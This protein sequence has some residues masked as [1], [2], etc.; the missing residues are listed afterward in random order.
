MDGHH[1][2]ALLGFANSGVYSS[3]RPRACDTHVGI[4][5]PSK[6]SLMPGH[7][8]RGLKN[9]NNSYVL[10]EKI[11]PAALNTHALHTKYMQ[12]YLYT[13]NI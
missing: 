7:F 6:K 11:I 1:L 13:Y 10:D 9:N 8:S 3:E 12:L 5:S 2:T 4:K